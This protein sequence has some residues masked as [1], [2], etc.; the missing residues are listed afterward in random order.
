MYSE[1]TGNESLLDY[2]I[3]RL[4]VKLANYSSCTSYILFGLFLYSTVPRHI[5]INHSLLAL[6]SL[7]TTYQL[8]QCHNTTDH[9]LNLLPKYRTHIQIFVILNLFPSC[10]LNFP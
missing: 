4:L 10:L 5:F 6:S 2:Y 1:Y 7:S 8:S 9:Q 3:F